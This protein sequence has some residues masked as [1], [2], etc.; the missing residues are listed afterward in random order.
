MAIDLKRTEDQCGVIITYSDFLSD[1]EY[2]RKMLDHFAEDIEIFSSYRYSISDFLALDKLDVTTDTI[3]L[4]ARHAEQA[5]RRNPDVVIA[6]VANQDLVF[7]LSRMWASMAMDL[8]WEIN[9][10]RNREDADAWVREQL[11]ARFDIH[12]PSLA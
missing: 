1:D 7:G 12:N 10:F 6:L 4:I 2:K 11:K 3:A 8:P 9:T 5:A